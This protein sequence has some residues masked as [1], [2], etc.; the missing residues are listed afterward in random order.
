MPFAIWNVSGDS[1]IVGAVAVLA[2]TI[3]AITAQF[4]LRA[5]LEHDSKVRERD[6]TRDAL[7]AVVTEITEAVQPMILAGETFRE[8]FRV[9]TANLK[10]SREHGAVQIENK[11]HAAV[12]ALRDR[13]SPL[14]AASFRLHLRFFDTDPIVGRLAD[15]RT[16]FD[17]LAEEYQA[18]LDSSDFEMKERF[19]IAGQTAIQ[20]GKKLNLFLTEARAWAVDPSG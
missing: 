14:M 5:Q 7:D 4:R 20:L 11:A 6:A 17:Q 3:A 2:A 10:T 9:R 16:T 19:D 15:W 13:R 12:Q 1:A 18:A 8:L